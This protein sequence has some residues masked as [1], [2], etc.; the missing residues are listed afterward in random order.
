MSDIYKDFYYDPP[1]FIDTIQLARFLEGQLNKGIPLEES[2]ADW[3]EKTK[4]MDE[5]PTGILE[6]GSYLV[7]E[8]QNEN[9]STER[10]YCFPRNQKES[11]II[12]NFVHAGIHAGSLKNIKL[13]VIDP[14][15]LKASYNM[16][17]KL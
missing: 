12:S 13:S 4:N 17:P 10:F 8:Y 7:V 6:I 2:G 1:D 15:I 9:D 5:D 16:S 14:S 3:Y 11:E